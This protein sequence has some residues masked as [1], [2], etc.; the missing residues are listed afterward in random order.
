MAC[1]DRPPVIQGNVSSR[2]QAEQRCMGLVGRP[3]K[4]DV[5]DDSQNA[6]LF[7]TVKRNSQALWNPTTD[8]T[9][10]KILDI[11]QAVCYCLVMKIVV[12]S[13]LEYL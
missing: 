9:A 10:D 5:L 1:P 3:M 4:K 12:F 2:S 8:P 11:M 7:D 6:S 13:K